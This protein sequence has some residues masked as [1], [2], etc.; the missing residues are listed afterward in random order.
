MNSSTIAAISTP[1][2]P[3][4]IGIIRISGPESLNILKRVFVRES[5]DAEF[6]SH[7]VYY[8]KIFD[9]KKGLLI[10][11]ALAIFMQAPKSFTREDVVELQSHSGFVVLDR[12]LS[13]VLD[14]G[15]SLAEAGEF[16]KRAFLNGRIDLSQAEAV[17]DMI[18]APCEAAVHIASQQMSGLL[19]ESVEDI[20]SALMGL[21]TR[22]EA[23]LEF[24]EEGSTSEDQ[25]FVLKSIKREILPKIEKLIQNQKDSAIYRDGIL[26]SIAG[27]PNVGKSSLLNQLVQK[28][29]AIVSEVPGTTRDIVREYLTIQGVPIV[30]CDTAGLHDSIDPVECLGI[31][32]TRNQIQQ[33]DTILFVIDASRPLMD[34]EKRLIESLKTKRTFFLLNKI[35]ISDKNRVDALKTQIQQDKVVTISAKTGE[36]IDALKDMLFRGIVESDFVKHHEVGIPNIR[37]RKL[38][39]KAAEKLKRCN[40]EIVKGISEDMVSEGLK[41]V[42]AIME[43]IIGSRDRED[44]YDTIFSQFCIGK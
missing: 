44:L 9:P 22:I 26:L 19:K 35:D 43:N 24:F 29:T 38:L 28:E 42:V 8:G 20:R 4:G 14:S 5:N 36:G 16:T 2:G 10:D 1:V 34:E 33:S 7:R 40:R 21:R 12:I 27:L 15:A 17:I 3:G 11:E 37:Q 31:E 30:L 6:Y 41:E 25:D 18:S 23:K 32:R 39:E 13:A